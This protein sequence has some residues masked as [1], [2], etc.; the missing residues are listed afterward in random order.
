MLVIDKYSV[1]E[2]LRHW[3]LRKRE[4]WVLRICSDVGIVV[5]SGEE[6]GSQVLLCWY[7]LLISVSGFGVGTNLD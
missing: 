4:E 6:F 7:N 1:S 3:K 2:E 5:S